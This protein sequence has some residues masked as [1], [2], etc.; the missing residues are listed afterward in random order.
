VLFDQATAQMGFAPNDVLVMA[1]WP[2]LLRALR[3]LVFTT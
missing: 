3:P 1:Q 2:D